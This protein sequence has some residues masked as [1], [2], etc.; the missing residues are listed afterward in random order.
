MSNRDRIEDI[1]GLLREAELDEGVW[2]TAS[3]LIDEV[4]GLRGNDLLLGR[5]N[6]QGGIEVE[7]RWLR[8]H[9][10]PAPE[11]AR[12]YTDNYAAIDE[13]GRAGIWQAPG[14]L[15]HTAALLPEGV[16][17]TSPT[18]NE[19]LVPNDG[20]NC[21]N[22]WLPGVGDLHMAWSLVGPGGGDPGDWTS[23]QAQAIR[24]LLPHVRQ[25]VL[26]RHALAEAR[27]EGTRAATLLDSRRIGIVLLDRDGRIVEANDHAR[28]TF[29]GSDGLAVRDGRLTANR[30]AEADR[31]AR[32]LDAAC[33]G[34][35]G[36]SMPITRP[37][38]PPL[39]VY[40]TPMGTT[41]GLPWKERLAARVLL[42]EPFSAPPVN[43]QRVSAALGLTPAQGRVAASLAAGGTVA[44]IAAAT[45]RTEA[46][47]RWHI[48]E[49]LGRLGLSRQADLVRVV[50]ST[51]GV[52][53]D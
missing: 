2:S 7:L 48:R 24:L 19:Y 16:R 25:F 26:V 36:G 40:A 21:L 29:G 1:I 18:Y 52:F 10:E 22:T 5:L 6:P 46:A 23:D 34:G 8:L 45:H 14:A 47:V 32:I 51:P 30:P 13:R 4:C 43:A 9:G 41:G 20:E 50:L 35:P 37:P 53:D 17:R 31:L 39:V 27:A 44:S 33:R 49:T 15:A 38:Q 28:A 12:D 11:L 42:A 3:A